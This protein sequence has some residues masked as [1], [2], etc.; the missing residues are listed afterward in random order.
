[1]GDDP[2]SAPFVLTAIGLVIT[3]TGPLLVSNRLWEATR[4]R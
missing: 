2:G 4:R 1:M 3:I